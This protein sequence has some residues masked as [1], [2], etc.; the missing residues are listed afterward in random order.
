MPA[1]EREQLAREGR[2][3]LRGLEDL[4]NIL[5]HRILGAHAGSHQLAVAH[6]SS[7]QIVEIMSHA[8]GK[9]S[10]R[11]QLLGLP[12]LL[13]ELFPLRDVVHGDHGPEF[14]AVY[15]Q[16]RLAAYEDGSR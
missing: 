2:R 15:V 3:T 14:A 12:Q 7:E 5:T 10:N 4:R 16:D 8:T 9:L 1:A 6:D 13:F 11:L